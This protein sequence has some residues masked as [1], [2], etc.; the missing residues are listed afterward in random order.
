MSDKNY[1]TDGKDIFRF[2]KFDKVAILK[3]LE[4]NEIV[5]VPWPD[6]GRL[7]GFRRVELRQPADKPGPNPKIEPD[8]GSISAKT[9]RERKGKCSKYYGVTSGY[10]GKWRIQ[11]KIKDKRINIG[12]FKTEIEAA[13]AVDAELERRGLKKKNFPS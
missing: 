7:D 4:T 10:K 2:E 11:L 3:N 8:T 6:D 1:F 12:G 13:K 9:R 5:R